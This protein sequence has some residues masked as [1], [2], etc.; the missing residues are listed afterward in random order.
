MTYDEWKTTDPNDIE[1]CTECEDDAIPGRDMCK[2][3]LAAYH[4][5]D[6]DK[7]LDTYSDADARYRQDM[8]D[9]GRGHLL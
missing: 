3:C 5:P 2:A 1:G 7:D 9:A 6:N 4:G 8:T